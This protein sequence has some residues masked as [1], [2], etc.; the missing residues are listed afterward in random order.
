MNLSIE[1]L[2]TEAD[3][4]S[5]FIYEYMD[6]FISLIMKDEDEVC[7]LETDDR[8]I[9]IIS[10]RDTIHI[11][12]NSINKSYNRNND[13][14]FYRINKIL[15]K[16]KNRFQRQVITFC[17]EDALNHIKD[18]IKIINRFNPKE[19]SNIEFNI[20][21]NGVLLTDSVVDAVITT[22]VEV[23]VALDEEDCYYEQVKDNLLRYKKRYLSN[24]N[25]IKIM[26]SYDFH[27][28]LVKMSDF[29]EESGLYVAILKERFLYNETKSEKISQELIDKYLE[30][31]KILEHKYN[32]NNL[33]G[34]YYS[35][36]L[37]LFLG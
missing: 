22:N 9:N 18:V 10:S 4:D 6:D 33:K 21:G 13:E 17:G 26:T 20:M 34:S 3:K 31:Y 1:V 24:N 11:I 7:F 36:F 5:Y 15:D 16:Y 37:K 30:E 23:Y 28:D 29:Y 32:R 12:F 19:G 27:T 25:S 14:I 8:D 35:S 2:K